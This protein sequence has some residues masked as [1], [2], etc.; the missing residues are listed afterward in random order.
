MTLKYANYILFIIF[1]WLLTIGSNNR[2]DNESSW[3]A[4][5]MHMVEQIRM[6]YESQIMAIAGVVM[7]S[8][9]T[10]ASGNP[11]LQIGTSLP[12]EVVR[13]KL[14]EAI[15]QIEVEIEYLGEIRTQ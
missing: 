14:P 4:D 11:C 3:M 1:I 15:F 6:D 9:G 2:S 10:C 7:V 8:T 12:I 5:Q 13:V